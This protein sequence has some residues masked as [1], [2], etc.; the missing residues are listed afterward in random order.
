MD[1]YCGEN[2][3]KQFISQ[4]SKLE[5]KFKT[6]FTKTLNGFIGHYEFLDESNT[7]T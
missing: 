3:P 6:D 5:I 4:E 1:R 7:S 2:V